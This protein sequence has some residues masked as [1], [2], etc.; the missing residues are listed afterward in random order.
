MSTCL[1]E[2]LR[3]APGSGNGSYLGTGSPADR[4]LSNYFYEGLAQTYLRGGDREDGSPPGVGAG[5]P[6]E[7]RLVR[8]EDGAG[9]GLAVPPLLVSPGDD[10]YQQA[11]VRFIFYW[12][13]PARSKGFKLSIITV[14]G[15]RLV[16]TKILCRVFIL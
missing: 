6:D 5:G 13:R 2:S 1:R 7:G 10:K 11:R 4:K 16:V 14:L 15:S 9:A 8:Q 3:P 12:Y